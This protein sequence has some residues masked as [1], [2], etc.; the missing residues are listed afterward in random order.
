MDVICVIKMDN[1]DSLEFCQTGKFDA[2][3]TPPDLHRDAVR[4]LQ[5]TIHH[6]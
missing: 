6:R 1:K 4:L 2:I 3:Q 5:L